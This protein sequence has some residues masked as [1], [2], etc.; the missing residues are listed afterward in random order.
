MKIF[1]AIDLKNN[2]CVRLSKGKDESS[3]V[4]NASPVEQAISFEQEGCSR[5]HLVDLDAAFGRQNINTVTIKNIRKAI[6]IPMQIGGGIRSEDDAK[7]LIDLGLNYLI[8]GSFSVTN[9]DKVLSFA[10]KNKD[11]IY[12]SLDI[13]HNKIM[14]N[15][16]EK[17]SQ[18]SPKDIYNNYNQSNIRGYILTDIEK[19]GMLVGLNI[20]MIAKNLQKTKKKLIVGGGLNSYQDLEKLKKFNGTNLEGVIA[21]KSYYTGNINLSKGQSILDNNA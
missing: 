14:I 6:S 18:F 11:S 16:W 7:E 17:T 3:I 4:F 1:P 20:E 19:D 12:V 10:E 9:I 15:G 2:K 5:I 13:L 8:I 21:G